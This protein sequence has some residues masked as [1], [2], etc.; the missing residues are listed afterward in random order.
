MRDPVILSEAKN[1]YITFTT[2]Y[3]RRSGV[4]QKPFLRSY[5]T[6]PASSSII[7][8]VIGQMALK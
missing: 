6:S 5:P 2:T 1:L 8:R 4:R 7:S 3:E